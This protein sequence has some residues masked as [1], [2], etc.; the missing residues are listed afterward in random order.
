MFAY[1]Q[2]NF[3]SGIENLTSPALKSS[4]T[5]RNAIN[6][7]G[8]EDLGTIRKV[9]GLAILNAQITA[10]KDITGLFQF[11]PYTVANWEEVCTIDGA[12]NTGK[13][14]YNAAGTWTA[15]DKTNITTGAKVD[16]IYFRDRIQAWYGGAAVTSADGITWDTTDLTS[17]P[18][19]SYPQVY[20]GRVH[21]QHATNLNRVYY[22]P[23]QTDTQTWVSSDWTAVPSSKRITGL[24]TSAKGDVL[25]VFTD[26]ASYYG[27]FYDENVG[28]ELK[29][30]STHGTLSHRSAVNYNNSTFWIDQYGNLVS[31]SGGTSVDVVGRAVNK[32][33]KSGIAAASLDDIS[34]CKK[35]SKLFWSL[36][37][38]TVS[39]EG[40]DD[41]TIARAILQYD[42]IDNAFWARNYSKTPITMATLRS[43]NEREK[44]YFGDNNGSIYEFDKDSTYT[45]A[46]AAFAC[47][48]NTQWIYGQEVEHFHQRKFLKEI[49]VETLTGV[50]IKIIFK[51][52]EG[53][54][55]EH[56]ISGER[57]E[58]TV[59]K[60]V[61]VVK[62]PNDE[63]YRVKIKFSETSG[64]QRVGL[65]RFMLYY[66]I[67]DDLEQEE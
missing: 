6:F 20:Q 18:S 29:F 3:S 38:V 67:V 41:T 45:D 49:M 58:F 11:Q 50:P 15:S 12:T 43:N 53:E 46:T 62:L 66:E 39:E 19:G 2:N 8:G 56:P 64:N 65:V 25:L 52:D 59:K 40:R 27:T 7:E 61:E 16:F 44:V 1:Y 37:S 4:D 60:K 5:V 22:T 51:F 21:I 47:E 31:F 35:D 24:K 55:G 33:T 57:Y 48:F 28:L 10:S 13:I 17:A 14:Y 36:G 34:A 23:V 32:S 9:N 30:L 54:W 63:F 42:A 26:E